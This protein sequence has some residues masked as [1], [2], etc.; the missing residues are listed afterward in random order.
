LLNDQVRARHPERIGD[1]FH[2]VSS[3][4]GQGARNS[5]FFD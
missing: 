4:G 2:G 3:R 1:R 5:R